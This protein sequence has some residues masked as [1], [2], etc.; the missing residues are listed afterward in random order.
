MPI[1]IMA[2]ISLLLT[3][4][5]SNRMSKLQKLKKANEIHCPIK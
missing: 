5:V 4:N 1:K 3:T 2:F